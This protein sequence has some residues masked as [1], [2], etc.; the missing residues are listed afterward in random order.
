MEKYK[1]LSWLS[2]LETVLAPGLIRDSNDTQNPGFLSLGLVPTCQL[3]VGC[4]RWPLVAPHVF[5]VYDI[6]MEEGVHLFFCFL[7]LHL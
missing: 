1:Q 5:L 6:Q 3:P 4:S 2:H 7:G